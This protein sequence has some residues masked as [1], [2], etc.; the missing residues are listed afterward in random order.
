MKTRIT[1]LLGI[2]Y[3]IIC[4]GMFQV[5]RAELAAAVSEAGGL[6][7]ITSKTF[8]TPEGLREEVRKV[9]ALT[10]KP[11]A[12]NLNLFP[13][14]TATPNEEFIDVLIQEGVKIVE[15]SGRSPK[16]LMPILKENGFIVIHKVAGVKY[17]KSA[18]KLG[19]DAL[20]VVG[21]ETGGHPGMGDV[22]SLV[23]LPKVV[24][25]VNIPVL[26]GGGFSDGRGLVS[27]LSLGA[28]GIVMGTRFMATREAPIHENVKNWMVEADETNTIVIQRNIGS[29]SRVAL[30]TVSKEV[31]KLENEGATIEDLL[32]LITG[33]RTKH[34]YFEG[35][36]DGGVWSC[37]QSVGLINEVLSVK[38]L[39]V[40]IGTEA[41]QTLKII[42][43][44]IG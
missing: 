25:A 29:P 12:V 6:G 18:E 22:G 21:N 43:E 34:V 30:N 3:P 38:E 35:D 15:T 41:E 39:L 5:G 2:K 33:Q 44:R 11:F 9:K 37:G 26:A 10:K 1:E 36:I 42:Q 24:D 32:P 7:T 31:N 28:E 14:Q 4:G 40:K 27:A 13:S 16:E 17:A 20:V 19:V 8:V 23:L